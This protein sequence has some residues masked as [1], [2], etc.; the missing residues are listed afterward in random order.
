[1][2]R[3]EI[4]DK[5]VAHFAVQRAPAV[6]DEGACLYRTDDGRKCA[7]GALI[8]DDAYDPKCESTPIDRLFRDLP[9][10]ME[11]AGLRSENADFLE[12]I[13]LIHDHSRHDAK[14][15]ADLSVGMAKVAAR[16]KLD[17][18]CLTALTEE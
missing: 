10:M 14:F 2:T 8:P 13:Q 12:D 7:V 11:A 15:L 3:Q 18:S 4:F 5:V 17:P 9:G 16:Y 6:D 1:M